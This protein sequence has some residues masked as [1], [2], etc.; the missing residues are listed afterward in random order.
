MPDDRLN[1]SAADILHLSEFHLLSTMEG[2]PRIRNIWLGAR[3][4]N[5]GFQN[6]TCTAHL[7]FA[8]SEAES[9][10]KHIASHYTPEELYDDGLVIMAGME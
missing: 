1:S 3:E 7:T 8:I 6:A 10:L 9:S 4:S 5:L 2:G